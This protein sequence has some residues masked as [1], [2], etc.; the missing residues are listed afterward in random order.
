MAILALSAERCSQTDQSH[1]PGHTRAIVILTESATVLIRI[2]SVSFEHF[3]LIYVHLTST[4]SA[5]RFV[6][7]S[8]SMGIASVFVLSSLLL[9]PVVMAEESQAFVAQNAARA[10]ALDNA[11]HAIAEQGKDRLETQKNAA[12]K[13]SASDRSDS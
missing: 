2:L 7:M 9:S 6:E 10:A 5:R 3:R 8:N 13:V 4:C 12:S 11:R 1:R